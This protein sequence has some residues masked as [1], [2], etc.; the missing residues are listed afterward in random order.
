LRLRH[1]NN[2]EARVCHFFAKKL[3]KISFGKYLNDLQKNID[4]LES[5]N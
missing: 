1:R 3:L 2:F 4:D 5:A